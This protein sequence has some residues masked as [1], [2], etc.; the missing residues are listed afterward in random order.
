MEENL[1]FCRVVLLMLLFVLG[2]TTTLQ[3][4]V[5]MQ[6]IVQDFRV[7][8]YLRW[9]NLVGET[10][11]E[12]CDQA[13]TD[14]KGI[15]FARL[16]T[17][18]NGTD[19]ETIVQGSDGRRAYRGDFSI[20]GFDLK[21]K[22]PKKTIPLTMRYYKTYKYSLTGEAFVSGELI[23]KFRH[24]G[25]AQI[26]GMGNISTP[27]QY[28]AYVRRVDWV[29][30]TTISNFETREV[31][32]I[33][34]TCS[35]YYGSSIGPLLRERSRVV[36]VNGQVMEEGTES[37]AYLT[38]QRLRGTVV[39]SPPDLHSAED[40][41]VFTTFTE[42]RPPKVTIEN[43]TYFPFDGGVIF[44]LCSDSDSGNWEMADLEIPAVPPRTQTTININTIQ[45][46]SEGNGNWSVDWWRYKSASWGGGIRQFVREWDVPASSAPSDIV[47]VYSDSGEEDIDVSILNHSQV[48]FNGGALRLSYRKLV[49]GFWEYFSVDVNVPALFPGEFWRK[50]V[51][52]DT[53]PEVNTAYYTGRDWL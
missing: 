7:G 38:E 31:T 34:D 49:L 14:P 39:H 8:D 50:R 24:I 25:S 48:S 11:T 10:W 18:R 45:G 52:D 26:R 32:E 23:G 19:A 30:T 53:V 22:K 36:R 41:P 9:Q 35:A 17:D 5:D 46:M 44:V 13:W 29:D 33:T 4:D 21:V 43:N 1:K 16:Y 51:I 42:G 2:G 40:F 28:N 20:A 47:Y 27:F 15:Q 6:V 37:A 3:A 12:N